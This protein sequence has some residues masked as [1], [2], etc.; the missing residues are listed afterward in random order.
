MV[1]HIAAEDLL[2]QAGQGDTAAFADF[3]DETCVPAYQLARCLAPHTADALLRSA[4]VEAWRTAAGFDAAEA[5]AL[6]WLLAVVRRCAR[7]GGLE[8]TPAAAAVA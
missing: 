2:V 8:S 7:D 3:Y 1:H 6:P 5:R 4:Y